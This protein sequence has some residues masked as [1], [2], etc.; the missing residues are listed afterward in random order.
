MG[1]NIQS[2]AICPFHHKSFANARW[3]GVTCDGLAGGEETVLRFENY[4]DAYRHEKNFCYSYD[5]RVCPIANALIQEV[6]D[7]GR[8][9][10]K[11]PEKPEKKEG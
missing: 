2:Y 7:E 9:S 3:F 8:V 6:L 10:F 11:K 4:A 5:Y 1:K